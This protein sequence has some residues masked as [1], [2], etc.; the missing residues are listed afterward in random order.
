MVNLKK[1]NTYNNREPKLEI[2]S[3]INKYTK[4]KINRIDNKLIYLLKDNQ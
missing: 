3:N 4:S 1:S 2:I